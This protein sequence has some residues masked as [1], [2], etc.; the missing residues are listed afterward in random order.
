MENSFLLLGKNSPRLRELRRRTRDRRNGEIILDGQRLLEDILSQGITFR[1]LYVSS[2]RRAEIPPLMSRHAGSCFEVPD[3]AFAKVSPTRHPQG[4]LA[5]VGEPR[6]PAW[7]IREGLAIF[8]E[9]IQDPS[10]VGAIIRAAA[11]LGAEAVWLGPGCAD[12]FGPRAVRASAGTIFRIPV[13]NS[14]PVERAVERLR[15]HDGRILA[16]GSGGKTLGAFSPE[17]PILLLIGNEGSGLSSK[18]IELADQLVG[19]PLDRGVESLNVAVASGILLAA[20]RAMLSIPGE[21]KK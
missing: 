2:S 6:L 9:E 17:H 7:T 1:E 4:I 20:F 12:P 11:G 3:E 5:I 13:E 10:N 8:L 19:I 15:S 16:T 18:A 21:T 14:L